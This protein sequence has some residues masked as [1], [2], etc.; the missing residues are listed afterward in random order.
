MGWIRPVKP[1]EAE[2]LHRPSYT[3]GV[4]ENFLAF[5]DSKR[6]KIT[7]VTIVIMSGER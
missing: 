3:H 5:S 4:L 2:E 1:L 6:G 7:F